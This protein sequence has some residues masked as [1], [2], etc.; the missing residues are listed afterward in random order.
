MTGHEPTWPTGTCI[1]C[2]QLWPC[3]PAV[4]ALIEEF[5]DGL[6]LAAALWCLFDE[7]AQ[8][9]PLA[10]FLALYER[11]VRQPLRARGAGE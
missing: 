1:A 8:A 10:S 11:C 9:L 5:G 4:A 6:P 2:G 7:A 3:E